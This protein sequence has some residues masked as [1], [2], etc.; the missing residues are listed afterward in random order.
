MDFT[1]STRVQREPRHDLTFRNIPSCHACSAETDLT[2]N[3]HVKAKLKILAPSVIQSLELL[4][5]FAKSNR[6]CSEGMGVMPDYQGEA[7]QSRGTGDESSP[8]VLNDLSVLKKREP[9]AQLV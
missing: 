4:L 3:Y 5:R 6:F 8:A 1:R 7:R 2:A 9:E